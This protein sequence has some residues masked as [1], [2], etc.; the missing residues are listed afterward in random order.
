MWAARPGSGHELVC[1]VAYTGLPIATVMSVKQVGKTMATYVFMYMFEHLV[2]AFIFRDTVKAI[3]FVCGHKLI[4][5]RF[6]C[7]KCDSDL[8]IRD[9]IMFWCNK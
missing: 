1:G 7:P 5:R 6:K 9:N 4:L 8:E 3:D 2:V